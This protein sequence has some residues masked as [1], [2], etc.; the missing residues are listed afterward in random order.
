MQK[1]TRTTAYLLLS[2]CLWGISFSAAAVEVPGLYESELAVMSQGRAERREIIRSAL[3]EV[4]IKVTGNT[5]IALSP[6]IPQI[7]SRSNQYLQQYRYRTEQQPVSKQYLWVRFDKK[8]LD[9]ALRKL[10]IAIW[11]RSRPSTLAWV[12]VERDGKRQ[13]LTSSEMDELTEV[14]LDKAKHRGIPV[15][16]PLLDIEDQQRINV[17]D[18]LA[19]F[20]DTIL[21]ASQRYSADAVLVGRLRQLTSQRW[22]GRWT[23][24]LAGQEVT[25]KEEGKLEDIINFGIDGV[26][27]TLA[28]NFVRMPSNIAGEVNVLVTDV[29]NLND[30]ARSDQFLRG[31]DGVIDVEPEKIETQS[32]LFKVTLRGDKQ[33][34][35]QAVRLSSQSVLASVETQAVP[36]VSQPLNNI[37]TAP[38]LTFKLIQ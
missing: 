11:G 17:S 5:S 7:L 13:L 33:S 36:V 26:T 38:L 28:S 2:L 3:L 37:A 25:W 30:Y 6:G 15:A 32:I 14:F 20:Q 22:Q 19:G 21:K 16:L 8:S 9:T 23:L 31:L 10:E 24:N 1:L 29:F 35:L 34:L 18:V 12:A 27:S 4:L